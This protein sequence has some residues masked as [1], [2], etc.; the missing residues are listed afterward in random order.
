MFNFAWLRVLEMRHGHSRGIS[1]RLKLGGITIGVA[2]QVRY[3]W[4]RILVNRGYSRIECHRSTSLSLG[5]E[6]QV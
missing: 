3:S 2:G 4:A 6:R 1:V 5:A